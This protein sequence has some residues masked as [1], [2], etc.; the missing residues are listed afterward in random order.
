MALLRFRS[1]LP[2]GSRRHEDKPREKIFLEHYSWLLECA[3]NITHGQRERA[4]DLVHDTFLEFL[5]YDAD[6]ATIT[7]IRN[8]LSGILRNLH[9]LLLRQA[10]R[11]PM[12]SFSL[13]D[14]DSALSGLR[15]WTSVEPFQ[16]A[17][18]LFR[19]SEFVCYR[20]ETALS[21]SIIIL[22]FFHGYYPGEIC[23]LLKA[24]R[25]MVDKWIERGRAETKEYL[26]SPYPLP[27]AADTESKW[28]SPATSSTFLARLRHRI[29]DSCTTDCA[30]LADNSD[31]MGVQEL[32]HLVSC[33]ACL[34][35]R[36]RRAGLTHVADRLAD[37]ISDRN[38]KEP[39]GGSGGIG[40][41]FPLRGRGT[42]PRKALLRGI[43]ARRRDRFEH[44][45]KEI[46]LVFDGQVH[47]TL[48]VN[49]T[50]NKLNLSL[51]A[52]EIP[53]SIAVLS[54]Q[55]VRFLLLN[56]DQLTCT[57]KRVYRL[58]LSEE[59]LLQVIVTPE[60][61]GPAVQVIYEDPPF[62]TKTAIAEEPEPL[63]VA[64]FSWDHIFTFPSGRPNSSMD[65]SRNWRTRFFAKPWNFTLPMNP[66]LTGAIALGIAAIVCFAFWLR[67]APSIAV[68]DLLGRAQKSESAATAS[69]LPGVIY[70]KV[71]I[72]TPRRSVERTVYRDAQGK[73]HPRAQQLSAEDEQLKSRLAQA[74]VNWEAPISAVDY[75][76]WRGH[77]GATRD[78]IA[79]SGSHLLTLTTTPLSVGAILKETITIRDTDF[80]AVDRTIELRDIGTIEIAELNYDVLPWKAV[81]PDWFE[82]EVS[83]V[84]LRG[85]H[86][87]QISHLPFLPSIQELDEAEL[88]A[89][90]VLNQLHAD[91]GEQIEITRKGDGIQVRG[92][93]ESAALKQEIGS[94]LGHIH[95]VTP[96]VF[97]FDE[98]A[99]S[100]FS[101]NDISSIRTSSIT[102]QSSPLEL[103]LEGKGE[104]SEQVAQ[105]AQNLVQNALAAHRDSKLLADLARQFSARQDAMT[106]QAH[107]AFVALCTS[108]RQDLRTALAREE[109]LLRSAGFSPPASSENHSSPE[110]AESLSEVA[111]ENFTLCWKLGSTDGTEARSAESIAREL[112]PAI[113]K[114][115]SMTR[116]P[117]FTD[118]AER[119]INSKNQ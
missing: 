41:V 64:G 12:E 32:A 23:L 7:N 38:D 105:L 19:A 75:A 61:F 37:D 54:E 51:D 71:R 108:H 81:N 69:D 79:F 112:F 56:R 36:S 50:T 15:A 65:I 111:A 118:A 31:D 11:H 47:A 66:L 49:G 4:E 55:D 84:P 29:F 103:A 35:R 43:D 13:L 22:R 14:Y 109:Q 39:Q 5:D 44:H 102:H 9:L 117:D 70:E 90:V 93:V 10:T 99:R 96:A 16:A 85:I 45:P 28:P 34:E 20:K 106:P 59:R 113:A 97:T 98:M 1:A 68:G 24:R 57:E 100:K 91:K 101:A 27:N 104:K 110:P 52:K 86:S 25:N 89:L 115:R 95:L 53:G 67:S 26:E 80:H 30:I 114:L 116:I 33:Q 63:T 6:L 82:P 88:S 48:M 58:H 18:L 2:D 87:L 42:P 40:K 94:Q 78:K 77:V 74:G 62:V 73:H 92:L 119:P 21:A 83:D 46:S 72:R 8:Y 3:L 17:D 107:S 76:F 60:A